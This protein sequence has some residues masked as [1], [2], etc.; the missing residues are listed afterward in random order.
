MLGCDVGPERRLPVGG[1]RFVEVAPV[2]RPAPHEVPAIPPVVAVSLVVVDL[3]GSRRVGIEDEAS[4]VDSARFDLVQAVDV[5]SGDRG[6][7]APLVEDDRELGVLDRLAAVEGRFPDRVA[8]L[9][10]GDLE[11]GYE[12]GIVWHRGSPLRTRRRRPPSQRWRIRVPLESAR[13]TALNRLAGEPAHLSSPRP[14]HRKCPICCVS[15][16]SGSSTYVQYACVALGR[17]PCIS[18]HLRRS[19]SSA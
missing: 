4:A 12:G 19:E 2:E 16:P 7:A 10:K 18:R 11:S 3:N 15:L 5:V 1:D 13:V 9:G 14:E 8:E 17:E 6:E